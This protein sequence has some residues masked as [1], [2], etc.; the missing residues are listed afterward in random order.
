MSIRGLNADVFVKATYTQVVA[1]LHELVV[2]DLNPETKHN[3][4]I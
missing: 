1:K 3:L 4:V 2:I